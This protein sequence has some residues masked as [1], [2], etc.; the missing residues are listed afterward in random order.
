MFVGD[1]WMGFNPTSC[2][3]IDINTL[4]VICIPHV[5]SL[6]LVCFRT[7]QDRLEWELMLIRFHFMQV[8]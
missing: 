3:K 1:G 8:D 6:A 7:I 2:V 5:F 4:V